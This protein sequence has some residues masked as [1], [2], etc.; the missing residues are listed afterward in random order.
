MPH[1]LSDIEATAARYSSFAPILHVDFADGVFAPNTTWM[2][3][4]DSRFTNMQWEAHLMVAAPKEL[5]LACIR[6]GA[7]RVIGHVEAMNDVENTFTAWKNAGA[8]ECVLGTLFDTPTESLAPH[9]PLCDALMVM[10]ITAIGVQGLPADPNASAHVANIRARYPNM[11][12]EVDGA[13]SEHTISALARA[14]ASRFCAGSVL[15]KSAD[16]AATYQMLLSLTESAAR[17]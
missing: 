8:Q 16:P 3:A 17:A 6:A 7:S 14:G 4:H 5:G 13:I 2:P 15:S 1:A 11:L 9:I 10:C 12:I